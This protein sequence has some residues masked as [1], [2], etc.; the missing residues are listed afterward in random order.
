VGFGESLMQKFLHHLNG[1]AE[2]SMNRR[3]YIFTIVAW[4]TSFALMAEEQQPAI[5]PAAQLIRGLM[6]DDLAVLQ[7]TGANSCL[8][9]SAPKSADKL[10]ALGDRL[11]FINSLGV[12]PKEFFKM[13]GKVRTGLNTPFCY[14]GDWGEWWRKHVVDAAQNHLP[15]V[16]NTTTDE[17]AWNNGHIPYLFGVPL[18][19]GHPFYC[20]CSACEKSFGEPPPATASRFLPNNDASRRFIEWRYRTVSE[21]LK[22]TLDAARTAAPDFSSYFVLN[23]RELFALERYPYGVAL[24]QL[25]QADYLVATCF[26]NSVDRRGNWTRLMQP[27]TAKYLQAARPRQGAVPAIAAMAYNFSEVHEWTKAYHWRDQVERLLPEETLAA[28]RRDLPPVPLKNHEIVLTGLSCIA[29]GARG[30]MMFGDENRAAIKELFAMLARLD[31]PLAGAEVPPEVIVLC[32]RQSE[33]EWM[34]THAPVISSNDDLTDSMLQVGCWAQPANRIAWEFNKNRTHSNGFRS[35]LAA[36]TALMMQGI[37]FRVHFAENLRTEDVRGAKVVVIPFC[38]HISDDTLKILRGIPDARL[39]A[40]GHKGELNEKGQHRFKAAFDTL[41][42]VKFYK[43]EA[44]EELWSE[45][46][47]KNFAES[48]RKFLELKVTCDDE[49]LERSWLRSKSGGVL[50]LLNWSANATAV[51]YEIPNART[52][53]ILDGQGGNVGAV[54]K[55]HIIVP[56]YSHGVLS[57]QQ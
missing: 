40:F 44:A 46:G 18:P 3:A 36:T 45:R 42:S 33:D 31:A 7:E 50:F 25:P 28:I 52:A 39:V 9:W 19:Q 26:Q 54:P 24:D 11:I 57:W 14:A 4:V 2:L 56:G 1:W 38:T 48:I 10:K 6:T 55:G 47:R 5:K 17:C 23:L 37:P 32:S 34:L 27:L 49:N 15:V 20:T 16:C 22:G 43:K 35:T 12:P 21:R 53:A 29:H 13:E 51:E 8:L 41:E 30:V